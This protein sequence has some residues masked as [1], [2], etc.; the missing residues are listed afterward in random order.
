MPKKIKIEI[1]NSNVYCDFCQ[2]TVEVAGHVTECA[3]GGKLHNRKDRSVCASCG[4]VFPKPEPPSSDI[5]TEGQDRESY[6]DTQ[7]RERYTV[8][9]EL[10][11]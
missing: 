3:C 4:R 5:G 2:E 7:D 10:E 11:Q 6:T 1:T 9:P 8:D